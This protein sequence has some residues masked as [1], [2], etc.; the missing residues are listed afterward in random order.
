MLHVE[1]FMKSNVFD[2]CGVICVKHGDSVT[3]AI[4][5]AANSPCF[6]NLS[7]AADEIP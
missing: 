2:S 6:D 1:H 3:N 4:P 7:V 5:M